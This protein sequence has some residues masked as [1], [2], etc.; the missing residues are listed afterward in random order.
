[1]IAFLKNTYFKYMLANNPGYNKHWEEMKFSMEII[2]PEKVNFDARIAEH[3]LSTM[4]NYTINP[5]TSL[6]NWADVPEESIKSISFSDFYGK[7]RV[8]LIKYLAEKH[9]GEF[10]IVGL[11]YQKYLF[12]NKDKIPQC[13][14]NLRETANFVFLG[15]CLSPNMG[16]W[17]F[18]SMIFNGENMNCSLSSINGRCGESGNEY[19]ILV[20]KF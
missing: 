18:P 17:A 3:D 16:G 19:I 5:E 11:E 1:M 7:P 8:E 6:V 12:A 13:I 20:K 2:S 10:S 14:N 4:G 15:S 9:A